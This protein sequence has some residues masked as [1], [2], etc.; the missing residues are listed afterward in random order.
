MDF[1]DPRLLINELLNNGNIKCYSDEGKLISLSP[2]INSESLSRDDMEDINYV[3]S[4][5]QD[6][7]G[8]VDDILERLEL[9]H[10]QVI[11]K[12]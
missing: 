6:F 2:N 3:K 4:V 9:S 5:E 8:N 1:V 12:N 11:P 10:L 7:R